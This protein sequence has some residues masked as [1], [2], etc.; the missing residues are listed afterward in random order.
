MER[1]QGLTK[2]KT[3]LLFLFAPRELHLLLSALRASLLIEERE[4]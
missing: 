3:D 4:N 1:G 2:R